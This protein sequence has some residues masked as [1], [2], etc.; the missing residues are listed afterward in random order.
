M[1]TKT[2]DHQAYEWDN[3]L[4]WETRN[5]PYA[6]DPKLAVRSRNIHTFTSIELFI[7]TLAIVALTSFTWWL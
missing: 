7:Y 3:P 2:T 6:L 4:W 1:N 5:H